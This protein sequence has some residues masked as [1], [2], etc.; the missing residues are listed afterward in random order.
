LTGLPSLHALDRAHGTRI[1]MASEA[2]DMRC[3]F[4]RLAERVRAVIG[5][6]PLGGH[7]FVFRS[8]RGDRV[9]FCTL[10]QNPGSLSVL[11]S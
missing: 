1:W 7:L 6:D 9:S 11:F 10:L 2:V 4:D 5:Q 8:R 3:G